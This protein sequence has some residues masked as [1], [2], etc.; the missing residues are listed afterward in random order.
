MSEDKTKKG[1]VDETR[2]VITCSEG[3][4]VK[5]N[6][7]KAT[8]G[9]GNNSKKP[10]DD[11]SIENCFGSSYSQLVHALDL[12]ESKSNKKNISKQSNT[13]IIF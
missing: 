8:S 11:Y 9:A 10:S 1:G 12:A 4:D 5:G 6:S 13:S 7:K 3:G 2:E